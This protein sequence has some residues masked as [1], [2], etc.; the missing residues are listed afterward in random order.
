MNTFYQIGFYVLVGFSGGLFVGMRYGPPTEEIEIKFRRLVQKLRGKDN[1]IA[2]G[3][4]VSDIVDVVD[5]KPTREER[6]AIRLA[7]REARKKSKNGTS[8]N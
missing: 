1:V 8:G 2:D 3:I 4:T 6:K 7:K 5:R